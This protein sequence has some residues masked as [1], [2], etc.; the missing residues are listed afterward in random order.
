M[1][2]QAFDL[3][4]GL[5]GLGLGFKNAGFDCRGGIDFWEPAVNHNSRLLGHTS[6]LE[7]VENAD[8]I[9]LES[10]WKKD[11]GILVGGPPCQGFSLANQRRSSERGAQKRSELFNYVDLINRLKPAAFAQCRWYEGQRK[12]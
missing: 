8:Q 3:Y 6:Y 7:K 9:I 4:C 10:G 5:G 1:K 2:W 12:C 11:T